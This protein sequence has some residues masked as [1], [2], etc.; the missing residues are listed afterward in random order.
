M[1]AGPVTGYRFDQFLLNL[2]RGCL[3][4]AGVDLG[5]R[6]KAFEVLR[7][8]VLRAGKLAAKNDIIDSVWPNVAASDDSLT[9]CVREIRARLGD[10]EQRFIKTVPRRGYIFVA[11]VAPSAATATARQ[12]ADAA[13]AMPEMLPGSIT[14]T[15]RTG[16]PGRVLLRRPL[17]IVALVVAGLGV[18]PL[19]IAWMWH[20]INEPE[21]RIAQSEVPHPLPGQ[22]SI[23]VMPFLNLSSDPEQGFLAA[24]LTQDLTS[25]LSR[26]PGVF[27][28][29]YYPA[30]SQD[31][32][33][34]NPRLIAQL[35]GVQYVLTGS[36]RRAGEQIR[37]TTQL[38]DHSGTHVWSDYFDA[39]IDSLFE[40]QDAI[41]RQ[42]LIELQVITAGELV[43][44]ASRGTRNL[45]AWLLAVEGAGEF[46]KFTQESNSR[47][48]ELY[49]AAHEADPNWAHALAGLAGT[50]W[51]TAR[52]GWSASREE[53]VRTGIAL[54]Q[55]A[56][57]MQ[58]DDS[59]GFKALANLYVESGKLVEGIALW[60]KAFAM[61]PT[62]LKS[63]QGLAWNLLWV[64]E[65]K[66][67]L[68]LYRDAKRLTPAPPW[69]L[70]AAEG[71]TLHFAGQH[72]AA[73]Q[74]LVKAASLTDHPIPHSRLAAVYAD[75][76][77]Q[78]D[79]GREVKQILDR[80]P[81]ATIEDFTGIFRFQDGA[82]IEWYAALLEK[83]GLSHRATSTSSSQ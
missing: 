12:S 71:L 62:D 16:R 80:K 20:W 61:T 41:I 77:R 47:A 70:S 14:K 53:D 36:V 45:R 54:A 15:G 69:P 9:Q 5:L 19:S 27:I 11:E 59:S 29:A 6:P 35:L 49:Q 46:S 55:R 48:R 56:I 63:I 44:I 43:R 82:Q 7:Y 67:A 13:V 66:R 34:E 4:K 65:E 42:V 26:T 32:L 25:A 22:P 51:N 3:Q 33:S 57:S 50:Y 10:D 72:E 60:E 17:S 81:D 30:Q 83:A 2:E 64:G 38:L 24:G 73:I 40:T 78:E 39:P 37:I 68:A 18:G 8:L 28:M 21:R 74:S 75:L 1:D 31:S 58:P 79:A 76:G 23:A 52:F